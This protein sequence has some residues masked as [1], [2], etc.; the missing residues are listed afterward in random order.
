MK[1][2]ETRI[3]LDA[4]DHERLR[5]AAAHA[6]ISMAEFVKQATL[7]RISQQTDDIVRE[8]LAESEALVRRDVQ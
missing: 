1:L 5:I 6:G 2:R 3:R 8:R 4:A 7:N